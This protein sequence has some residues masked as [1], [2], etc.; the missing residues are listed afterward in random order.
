METYQDE[1]LAKIA[2]VKAKMEEVTAAA[3]AFEQSLD[4]Q[5]AHLQNI[6]SLN[7][8]YN[9]KVG[10]TSRPDWVC[11][12]AHS[13]PM[14]DGPSQAD[15]FT[16][17]VSD[18]ADELGEPI[19]VLLSALEEL[20]DK[21]TTQVQPRLDTITA[22]Y[23]ELEALSN[24]LTEAGAED[25]FS[26][27]TLTA[28][29]ESYADVYG[30]MG[31]REEEL[32]GA[33][34]AERERDA[35]RI[36]FAE[37][38]TDLRECVVWPAV[39][40]V[41]RGVLLTLCGLALVSRIRF[42]DAMTKKVGALA[43]TLQEQLEG[44][45]ALQAEF[46]ACTK[47]NDVYECATA[48][49]EAGIVDN[50]HTNES[51][52]SLF[53]VW[54]GLE[55]VFSQADES[56]Q[57]QLLAERDEHITPEQYKEIKEVFNHFD[58]NGDDQLDPTEFSYCCTSIGLVLTKE[59]IL[60]KMAELDGTGDGCVNFQE[61]TTFMMERLVEP[62]HTK[63]DVMEAFLALGEG[64]EYVTKRILVTS[65]TNESHLDYVVER[66]PVVEIPAEEGEVCMVYGDFVDELFT[67]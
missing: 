18:L 38:A 65:F 23:Q 58:L 53:A 11:S 62:G 35:K 12:P 67:R 50:P 33:L 26:R 27:F 66:L 13:S 2:E 20:W 37:K 7:K 24:Q 56:L 44:L 43:G 25:A 15:S 59:E 48:M 21:F 31:T 16:F 19:P 63:A 57:A 4:T 5:E 49:E 55:K 61:F 52:H 45:Q 47:L 6:M 17:D 10:R 64:E 8:Q 39:P 3:Q 1:I 46:E 41:L 54:D 34:T 22:A 60:T 51:Y 36:E 29:Y 42:A 32:G 30:R 28:L 9:A 40:P 14:A